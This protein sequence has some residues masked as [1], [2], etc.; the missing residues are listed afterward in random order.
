[1]DNYEKLATIG[2][3]SFGKVRTYYRYLSIFRCI[4]LT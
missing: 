3:G 1:M 2:K 4:F